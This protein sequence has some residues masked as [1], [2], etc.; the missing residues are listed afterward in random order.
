MKLY[1]Q[2][3]AFTEDALELPLKIV[4]NIHKCVTNTPHTLKIN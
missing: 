3:P 1:F 2:I 4:T